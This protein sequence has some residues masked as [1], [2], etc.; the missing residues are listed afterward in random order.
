MQYKAKSSSSLIDLTEEEQLEYVLAQSM[1]GA[2]VFLDD[3]VE[4]EKAVDGTY[5]IYFSIRS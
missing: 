4:E 5:I 3:E 2:D 1:G